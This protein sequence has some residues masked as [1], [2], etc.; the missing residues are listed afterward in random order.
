M[1]KHRPSL[2][3]KRSNWHQV[4]VQLNKIQSHS[5]QSAWDNNVALYDV[6]RFESA[7]EHLELIDFIL[8][9]NK[10]HLTVVKCVA[11]GE[12]D[13]IP[14]QSESQAANE[15][16]EFTLLPGGNKPGDYQHQ[17]LTYGY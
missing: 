8:P 1:Q 15:L 2:G 7:G 14:L 12:S 4:R 17:I 6:H 10:Y 3:V 9:N 16:P 5:I 11:G 13:P